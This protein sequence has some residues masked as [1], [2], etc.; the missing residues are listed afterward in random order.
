MPNPGRTNA[1][2]RCAGGTWLALPSAAAPS[3]ADGENHAP[4]AVSSDMFADAP[5]SSSSSTS[6][7]WADM[8]TEAIESCV[9]GNS[10][11]VCARVFCPEAIAIYFWIAA[12][13][14]SLFLRPRALGQSLPQC[15]TQCT[16]AR[17]VLQARQCGGR[18][19][20][21]KFG[22]RRD[23]FFELLCSCSAAPTPHFAQAIMREQSISPLSRT[24]SNDNSKTLA[25]LTRSSSL[26]RSFS[27]HHCIHPVACCI[28]QVVCQFPPFGHIDDFVTREFRMN[29]H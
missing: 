21:G 5:T 8:A 27:A 15:C 23:P 24:V 7:A 20:H 22:K 2:V 13:L 18:P 26:K 25:T 28:Q 14:L 19:E 16:H 1:V 9:L 12:F 17:F 29:L 3:P 11:C 10:L 6:P 4:A